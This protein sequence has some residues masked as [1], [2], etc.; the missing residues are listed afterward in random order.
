M[1]NGIIEGIIFYFLLVVVFLNLLFP[2]EIYFTSRYLTLLI[3]FT[4]CFLLLINWLQQKQLLAIIFPHKGLFLII[5]FLL[6]LSTFASINYHQSRGFF[7]LFL[8]YALIFFLVQN[9]RIEEKSLDIFF[10]GIFIITLLIVIYGFYQYTIGFDYLLKELNKFKHL[11]PGQL[12]DI[13]KRIGD[14]RIFSTF[15]L[16]TTLAGFLALVLPM[17]LAKCYL[18]WHHKRKLL[19]FYLPLSFLCFAAM[20]AT[21]SFG[22]IVSLVLATLIAFSF[23]L[24][25]RKEFRRIIIYLIALALILVLS[26]LILAHFRGFRLWNLKAPTNPIILRLENW[27]VA[28]KIAQDFPF[29]GAGL[30]NY[31]TIYPK[32]MTIERSKTQFAHNTLLQF[33]AEIG[34]LAAILIIVLVFLLLRSSIRRIRKELSP[35][36]TSKGEVL[37]YALLVSSLT[38]AVHNLLE[39]SLY[40]YSIGILGIFLFS[41]LIKITHKKKAEDERKK[42]LSHSHKIL[43]A[44]I[45]LLLFIFASICIT[46]PLVAYIYFQRAKEAAEKEEYQKSLKLI[47]SAIAWDSTDSE[48]YSARARIMTEA[49]KDIGVDKDAV[50]KDYLQAIHYNPYIPHLHFELSEVYLSEGWFTS[51]YLEAYEARNLYPLNKR[52]SEHLKKCHLFMEEAKAR[53]RTE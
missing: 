2:G 19:L 48:Y 35:S 5:F 41:L 31:G 51:A 39:I 13:K 53:N 42:S 21:G 8:C 45:V 1:S 3:S 12:M 47:S 29:F 43:L 37:K 4:L 38:F 49:Q 44:W 7:F 10:I 26:L 27:T 24:Y 40:F 11:D 16:P 17:A 25:K 23:L 9:L 15:V 32:Y 52:Y 36:V 34:W 18:S 28:L 22:A 33:A 20:I 6:I 50:A 14:R 30:G 46:R